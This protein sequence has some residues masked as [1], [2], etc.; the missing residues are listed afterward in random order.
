MRFDRVALM[1]I[2]HDPRP[3]RLEE[4]RDTIK[5]PILASALLVKR[6]QLALRFD[7]R[8]RADD[9][10]ATLMHRPADQRHPEL[11]LREGRIEPAGPPRRRLRRHRPISK[12]DAAQIAEEAAARGNELGA[13]LLRVTVLTELGALLIEYARGRSGRILQVGACIVRTLASE[14]DSAILKFWY[15]APLSPAGVE[16]H[17]CLPFTPNTVKVAPNASAIL[18][19]SD[20]PP[21]SRNECACSSQI[22]RL[23]LR[24]R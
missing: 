1:L 18:F 13:E 2:R 6:Q 15:S 4:L 7:P 22:T 8:D 16:I 11:V 19:S 21:V 17:T 3:V 23:A 10:H 14:P 9:Q 12:L 20:G 5:R 24:P